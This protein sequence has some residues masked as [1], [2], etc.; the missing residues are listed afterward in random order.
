MIGN[1]TGKI[2]A[3]DVRSKDCRKCTY[4][5]RKGQETPVHTVFDLFNAPGGVT[6]PERG[7]IIRTHFYYLKHAYYCIAYWPVSPL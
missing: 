5:T 3:Y 6:F 1:K 7:A 4:Y 2:V